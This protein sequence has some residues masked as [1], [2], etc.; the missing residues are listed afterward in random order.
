MIKHYPS[1]HS[2]YPEKPEGEAPQSTTDTVLEDG[3]IIRTCNDCGA[4]EIISPV[5]E[6]II[7]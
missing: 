6:G 1:C 5:Q 7:S 4:D 2:D 3:T